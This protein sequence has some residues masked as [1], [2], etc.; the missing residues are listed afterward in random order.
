VLIGAGRPQV[1]R[2][3]TPEIASFVSSLQ[4]PT[5]N[6]RDEGLQHRGYYEKLDNPGRVSLQLWSVLAEKPA[7]W[8]DFWQTPLPRAH[9]S[10]LQLDMHPNTIVEQFKGTSFS[11]N[12]W[13]M[14][15]RDRLLAKPAGTKRIAVLGPSYV[16][17][18]GVG[19]DETFTKVL[20]GLLNEGRSDPSGFEVLN[21]GVAGYS[22]LQELAILEDRVLDFAPDVVVLTASAPSVNDRVLVGHLMTVLES[23][24]EIPYP[25]L[26]AILERV[27][28][29]PSEDRGVPLPFELLRSAAERVGIEARLPYWEIQRRVQMALPDIYRWSLIHS[30]EVIRRGG[31]VPV[32]L[33]L[34]VVRAST[35]GDVAGREWAE[36]AG[37]LVWNSLDV[38][39]GHDAVQLRLAEW[40]DHP[41]AAGHVLIAERLHANIR[42][43]AERLRLQPSLAESASR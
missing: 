15:D 18:T 34:D 24:V 4:Q 36:E 26:V 3:A 16:M 35:R 38:Y 11:T 6:A 10:F 28:I 42:D 33:G 21:F 7:D 19:D 9:E 17:G 22:F 27:G 32:L 37:F 43:D 39:D 29:R 40:D 20:E 23:G 30:A 5:L 14:R 12:A 41:N 1:Q 25:G 8:I 13:G 31:A 2:H